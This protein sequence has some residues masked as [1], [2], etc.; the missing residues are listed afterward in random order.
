MIVVLRCVVQIFVL[1]CSQ[2]PRDDSKPEASSNQPKNE[3]GQKGSSCKK[4]KMASS[5]QEGPRRKKKEKE[6][7]NRDTIGEE[8]EEQHQSLKKETTIH[9]KLR[10]AEEDGGTKMI[11]GK[12]D[13]GIKVVRTP[14]PSGKRVTISQHDQTTTKLTLER[15]RQDPP[16]RHHHLTMKKNEKNKYHT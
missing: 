2:I 9:R 15:R 14:V 1:N 16:Q 5:R 10:S 7:A 4:V 8:Y 12:N 6:H 13:N 3:A 11:N